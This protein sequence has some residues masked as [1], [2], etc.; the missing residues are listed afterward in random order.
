MV[1][2]QKNGGVSA[3]GQAAATLELLIL[4]L[5]VSRSLGENIQVIL[6]EESKILTGLGELTLLH[7]L[8]DVPVDEGALGVHEVELGNKTLLED[9]GDGDVVSDHNDVTRGV[10]HVVALN[11]LRGL[12]V[13]ADLESGR[14]PLDEG[15]LVLAL[16]ELRRLVGVAG[17]DVSTVVQGDGHVLI[18]LDVEV[19]VLD[20]EGRRLE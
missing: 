6:L 1:M 5:L 14:A 3:L 2:L 4:S 10:G 18:L 7:T 20:K 9:A 16:H 11:G 15:D 13:K 19:R 12:V 8:T 17:A